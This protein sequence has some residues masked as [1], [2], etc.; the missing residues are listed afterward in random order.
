MTHFLLHAHSV[1]APFEKDCHLADQADLADHLEQPW[2]RT[3]NAVHLHGG[4]QRV[5]GSSLTL[6][7]DRAFPI[8]DHAEFM[9]ISNPTHSVKCEKTDPIG[10]VDR[11]SYSG[12]ESVNKVIDHVLNAGLVVGKG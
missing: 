11:G 9:V 12:V 10:Q 6:Y 5:E 1:V 2:N 8:L 7:C 3:E 4:P